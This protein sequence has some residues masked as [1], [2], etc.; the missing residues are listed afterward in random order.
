MTLLDFFLQQQ[1]HIINTLYNIPAS[2]ADLAEHSDTL[3]KIIGALVGLAGFLLWR[4]LA[5]IETKLDSYISISHHCKETLPERHPTRSEYDELKQARKD[6][7]LKRDT[8]RDQD[9]RDFYKHSHDLNGKVEI[10]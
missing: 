1:E 8:E 9:V 7:W 4:I 2:Q 3:V 10:K 5:R 6:A